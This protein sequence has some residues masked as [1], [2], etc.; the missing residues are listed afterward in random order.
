[1][2]SLSYSLNPTRSQMASFKSFQVSPC[3]SICSLAVLVQWC[4]R[5]T[6]LT[7]S[8]NRAAFILSTVGQWEGRG[9]IL[10]MGT[11]WIIFISF[12]IL[13]YVPNYL[14]WSCITCL[15]KK[16]NIVF[17]FYWFLKTKLC[18]NKSPSKRGPAN[19]FYKEPYSKYFRFCGP[20]GLC[21]SNSVLPL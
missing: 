18:M 6:I 11:Q 9:K 4:T 7:F 17:S 16:E 8:W 15:M 2:G 14:Q 10:E 3:H 12:F 1:M 20:W 21:H 5:K 13:W 19:F